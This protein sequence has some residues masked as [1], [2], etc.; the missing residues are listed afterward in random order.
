MRIYLSIYLLNEMC[1]DVAIPYKY[2][3]KLNAHKECVGVGIIWYICSYNNIKFFI[4][5]I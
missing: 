4:N 5:I 3:W 1:F 2:I